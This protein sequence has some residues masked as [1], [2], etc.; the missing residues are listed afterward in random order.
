MIKKILYEKKSFI[1]KKLFMKKIKK[2]ICEKL[3]KK[4]VL[5]EKKM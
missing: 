3:C 4:K 1:K 2:I 5:N